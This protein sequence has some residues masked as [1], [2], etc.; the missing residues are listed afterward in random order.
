LVSGGLGYKQVIVLRRDLKLGRGKA[1][2]QAAHASVGAY[3]RAVRSHRAWVEAWEGE[4]QRKVAVHV[5]TLDELVA[6]FERAKRVPL[7]CFLVADAGLTEVPPGTVTALGIGP[8]P[9]ELVDRL[10]GSLPLV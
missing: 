9:S 7:P 1:V 6:L 4:G 5:E 10:T 8:A 2:V 3:E